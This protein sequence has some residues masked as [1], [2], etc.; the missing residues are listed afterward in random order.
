MGLDSL[1]DYEERSPYFGCIAGRYANRIAGGCFTLD[2]VDYKLAT[3][4][5]SNHLHGGLKGFDKVVWEVDVVEDVLEL[6]YVSKDMEEGYPG[7]LDVTVSYTLTDDN[8]LKIDY[9]ARTDKPTVLNLTNHTYFNLAGHG[10]GNVDD[11][12]QVGRFTV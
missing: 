7:T 3:N 2:G 6:H 11:E 1:K 4:N 9:E 12:D 8:Q 5:G 10:A